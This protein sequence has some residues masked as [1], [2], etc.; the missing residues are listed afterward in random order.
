MTILRLGPGLDLVSGLG[1]CGGG[2]LGECWVTDLKT[3]SES[4][5]MLTTTAPFGGLVACDAASVSAA[6]TRRS[7]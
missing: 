7:N 2:G 1:S 3:L 4:L 6:G 5:L